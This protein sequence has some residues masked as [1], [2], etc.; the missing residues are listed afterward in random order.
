MLQFR[1]ICREPPTSGTDFG[2]IEVDTGSFTVSSQGQTP[3]KSMMIFLSLPLLIHEIE[4]LISEPNGDFEFVGVGSSFSLVFRREP[5]TGEV[6]LRQGKSVLWKGRE[7]CLL[8][9]LAKASLTFLQEC[10]QKLPPTDFSLE[11]L[12]SAMNRLND[13]LAQKGLRS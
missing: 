12:N 2:D 5:S 8:I 13:M 3:S 6:S 11:D 10:A 4:K 1:F 9:A 7:D